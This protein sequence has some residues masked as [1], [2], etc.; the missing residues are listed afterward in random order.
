MIGRTRR[1]VYATGSYS[2]LGL[3]SVVCLF[4]FAWMLDTALKPY[5]EVLTI[6]PSFFIAAPTLDNFRTVLLHSAIPVYFR[7]S[8]VVGLATTLITLVVAIFCSYVLS[9]WPH[10]RAAQAVG[11]ALV[12]SQMVPGVLLL[13]PLYILMRSLHLLSTYAALILT[14][15]TFAIPLCVFLLKNFF[16]TIP[17]DLEEAAELDGCGRVGFI[18]RGP[19]PLA[20]PGLLAI[21]LFVFVTAWNEFM[22]GY[23][24]I[25]DEARRTL[26][27]G[28]MI[29][30]GPH[31]TDWGSLMAASAIS[32]LPVALCFVWLQRLLVEGLVAGAVKG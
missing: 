8:V 21:G 14:Y 28:I 31:L 13:V 25:D 12:L 29:F 26:T 7:N 30:K 32:V 15:C 6:H 22:F 11:G 2:V 3:L 18:F 5:T 23:V 24:L 4:P 16:D 17:R 27:P 10:M 1:L 19:L 9:R 20:A